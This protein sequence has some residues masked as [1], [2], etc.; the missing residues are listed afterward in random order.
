MFSEEFTFLE[1]EH[2]ERRREGSDLIVEEVVDDLSQTVHL[3]EVTFGS[4]FI[5]LEGKFEDVAHF[6]DEPT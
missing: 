6:G 1:A 4:V 2:D 3:S 5:F